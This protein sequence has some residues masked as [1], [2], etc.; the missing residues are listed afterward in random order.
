MRA[1]HSLKLLSILAAVAATAAA[2]SAPA[3]SATAQPEAAAPAAAAPAPAAVATPEPAAPCVSINVRW[4][5]GP[6]DLAYRR[7]RENLDALHARQRAS[8]RAGE[9]SVELTQRQSGESRALEIRYSQGKK[10]HLRG[11]PPE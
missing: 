3:E 11:M 8:L 2:C 5:S 7:E 4:D 6:L 9:S 10:D 1:H